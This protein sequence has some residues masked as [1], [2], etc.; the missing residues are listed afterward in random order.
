MGSKNLHQPSGGRMFSPAAERNK[1]PIAEALSQLLPPTGRVLEIGSGTGQHVLHFA[2]V[3]PNLLWQPTEPDSD[4]LRSIAGWLSVAAPAN[5]QA[6]LRLDVHDGAWP[7]PSADAIVCINVL[8]IAAWSATLD[9]MRGA[10]RTLPADGLVYL[11]GPYRVGGRHTCASNQTFD[12]HLR[13][14]NPLWGVRELDDV[15]KVAGDAGFA[16][17]E[18]MAMPAN[19]MGI[20]FRK[21]GSK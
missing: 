17:Q 13:A 16:L 14:A 6:P 11:Y 21:G 3:M 10:D 4:C 5:V 8:H 1:G 15:I 7:L 2:R 18:R 20:V 12:A 19:N 9:L